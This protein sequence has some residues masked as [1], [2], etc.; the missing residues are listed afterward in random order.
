MYR[1]FVVGEGIVIRRIR[2]FRSRPDPRHRLV[3]FLGKNGLVQFAVLDDC[4]VERDRRVEQ[5]RLDTAQL[6]QFHAGC[7]FEPHEVVQQVPILGV[8]HCAKGVTVQ[9]E[10]GAVVSHG[11]LAFQIQQ[12]VVVRVVDVDVLQV[13][14]Q[15]LEISFTAEI[16]RLMG[17]A[18]MR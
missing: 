7:L 2:A 16:L 1:H 12:V 3:Q 11:A 15:L 13:R 6:Q 17:R 8:E 10:G 5:V 14:Q 9:A 4:L 18:T